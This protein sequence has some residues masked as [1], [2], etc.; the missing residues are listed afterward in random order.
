M[1]GCSAQDGARAKLNSAGCH[2]DRT[3]RPTWGLELEKDSEMVL[4][5]KPTWKVLIRSPTLLQRAF[6]EFP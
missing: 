4:M 3:G 2:P 1:P 5:F 6:V